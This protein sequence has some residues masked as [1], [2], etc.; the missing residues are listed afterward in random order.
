MKYFSFNEFSSSSTAKKLGIDNTI[1]EDIKSNIK[2][3]VGFLLDPLRESWEKYC[4][5]NKLGNPAIIVTSGYR[6]TALNKAVKGKT[7]S[8][9]LHGLAADIVPSNDYLEEFFSFVKSWVKDKQF[10]Q[11]I[12]EYSKWIHLSYR[13]IEGKQ[14]KQIFKIG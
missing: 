8:A 13:N 6:C 11:C 9:H 12:E 3:L 4:K 7:T 2:D 14:R 10:D 5:S 1:P